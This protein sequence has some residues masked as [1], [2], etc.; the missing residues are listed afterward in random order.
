[1][2]R[3]HLPLATEHETIYR[4]AS[5]YLVAQFMVAQNGGTADWS[6]TGLEAIYARVHEVNLAIARRLREA[7]S[8]DASANALVRLDLFAGGVAY[9]LRDRLRELGYLFRS[10]YLPEPD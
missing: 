2:A 6:L 7:A 4:A 1:M 5:M 9:S 3:F 10:S 8:K